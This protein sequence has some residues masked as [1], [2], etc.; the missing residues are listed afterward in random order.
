[1]SHDC[2]SP[3]VEAL[4]DRR[5]RSRASRVGKVG[6]EWCLETSLTLPSEGRGVGGALLQGRLLMLNSKLGTLGSNSGTPRMSPTKH[7]ARFISSSII[8]VSKPVISMVETVFQ[9][10]Y[11]RCVSLP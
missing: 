1:M 11:Q 3:S 2:R 6:A 7:S 10:R 8:P 4:T 5:K 9:L